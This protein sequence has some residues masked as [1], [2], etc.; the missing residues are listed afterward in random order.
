[1]TD[2]DNE[3][4]EIVI[5]SEELANRIYAIIDN[6]DVDSIAAYKAAIEVAAV[7][8]VDMYDDFEAA[9]SAIDAARDYLMEAFL[10]AKASESGGIQ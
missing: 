6:D 4:D 10:S 9:H 8:L 1:M 2:I 3:Y 5:E 7:S